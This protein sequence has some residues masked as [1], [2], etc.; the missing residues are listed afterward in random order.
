SRRG[1]PRSISRWNGRLRAV[2][3]NPFLRSTA[4]RGA[5]RPK[6]A[7]KFSRGRLRS[8][9]GCSSSCSPGERRRARVAEQGALHFA[10]AEAPWA[11]FSV[12]GKSPKAPKTARHNLPANS[13]FRAIESCPSYV[14][15]E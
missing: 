5:R 7:R 9:I 3:N 15:R 14:L 4:Q 13:H 2:G 8:S 11:K 1:S 10:L 6:H 12:R